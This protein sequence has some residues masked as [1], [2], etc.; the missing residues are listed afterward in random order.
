MK[1]ILMVGLIFVFVGCGGGSNSV[2]MD[3]N[4]SVDT[5]DVTDKNTTDINSS[6]TI[7][8]NPLPKVA[9]ELTILHNHFSSNTQGWKI[10]S[11]GACNISFDSV[12]NQDQNGSLFVSDRAHTYDG[13][14]LNITSLVEPDKLY[15]IRGYIK[16]KVATADNYQ[17]MIK[18]SSS[19]VK[20]LNYNRILVNNTSWNKFRAFVSFTQA[21]IDAGLELYINSD[22]NTN[23]FYLD[24]VEIALSNYDAMPK[25][26]DNILKIA[27]GEIVDKNGTS[28]TIKGVNIIA[29]DD[30]DGSTNDQSA[31]KFMN[32]S[33]YNYDKDDFQKIK[34]MGFNAVRIALWYRYFEDESNPYIYK[35]D[36]FAWLDTVVAWAKEAG[37]FV[38]LDMHAPQGGGFQGP[39]NI[40]AFWSNISYRERFKALWV[41]MAKH[42]K[43]DATIFAYDIINEPCA[44][45][46]SAYLTLLGETI[47]A[48]R[49]I[50]SNHIINVENGFSSDNSPFELSGYENILYDFHY[51]DPWS[52][53]TNSN[54]AVYGSGGIDSV[55][56]RTLFEDY[57]DYYNSKNLA[58]NI[59]EFGQKYANFSSKNSIEWVSDLIDLILEKKG[60]YFYFSYKGNEF[61]IYESKNSF[62]DNSPKNDA[63]IELLKSK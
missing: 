27:N 57:S 49:A 33:Y 32:Y 11:V 55:Q 61:G 8:N 22:T 35:A 29:Y 17:V 58:F 60:N 28:V 37:I 53:F 54:T 24:E 42:Y 62:S 2:L 16:Q 25:N 47:D 43:D 7:D 21:E 26:S 44:S 38:M 13:P 39:N 23:D 52:G 5:I 12:E 9:S 15:I 63:L 34:A 14:A 1:K 6:E 51:Y 19:P 30:D 36:G 50:D 46:Q 40:T 4:S 45:K 48:I 10:F 20:Y 59:S 41:E 18:V 56:M 31:K 3:K